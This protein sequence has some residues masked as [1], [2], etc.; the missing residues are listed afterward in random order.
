MIN[1]NHSR[2]NFEDTLRRSKELYQMKNPKSKEFTSVDQWTR[3]KD[4]PRFAGTVNNMNAKAAQKK[5]RKQKGKGRHAPDKE[6]ESPNADGLMSEQEDDEG[7][8]QSLPS[9]EETVDK[10]SLHYGEQRPIRNKIAKKLRAEES[11][12]Q[13]MAVAQRDMVLLFAKQLKLQESQDR[14]LW[15]SMQIADIDPEC[16]DF[17]CR[18]REK[19]I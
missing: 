5:T 6:N 10:E 7:C 14:Q 4:C 11:N 8:R 15:L 18:C 2:D 12:T 3:L 19:E 17:F 13:I 1:A 9:E 16:Q